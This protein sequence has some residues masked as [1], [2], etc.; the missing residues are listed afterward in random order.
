MAHRHTI[1]AARALDRP[2]IDREQNRLAPPKFHDLASCLH[3]RPIFH[4]HELATIKPSRIT[5][6]RLC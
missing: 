2:L 5:D 1:G 4:E 6:T 3:A